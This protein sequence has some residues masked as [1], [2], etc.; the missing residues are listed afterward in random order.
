MRT[1]LVK[2]FLSSDAPK[3]IFKKLN[4]VLELYLQ[5]IHM[6]E[7]TYLQFRIIIS[8][9]EILVKYSPITKFSAYIRPIHKRHYGD[10]HIADF[11]VIFLNYKLIFKV[12]SLVF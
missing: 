12:S 7:T 4:T 5:R 6:F 2:Q 10:T 9:Y 1:L 8:T 3:D 11:K